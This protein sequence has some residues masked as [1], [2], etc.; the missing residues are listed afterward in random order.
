MDLLIRH[1]E[2]NQTITK[3][4]QWS[5]NVELEKGRFEPREI[6]LI[7]ETDRAA[8]VGECKWAEYAV[9]EKQL[10]RLQESA[11]ALQF[12]KPVIWVLFSKKKSTLKERGDLL[13]FD[14]QRLTQTP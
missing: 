11:Q 14:A 1:L 2:K 12:K 13:L 4:G 8:Y 7:I 5:G 10:H 3:R 6:D 9:G